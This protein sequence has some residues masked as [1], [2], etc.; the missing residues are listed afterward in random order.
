MNADTCQRWRQGRESYRPAGEPIDPR[1]YRVDLIDEAAA[2]AFVVGHHYS[3]SYPAAVCRAG[4]FRV[5][6]G[7][8]V[9]LVGA[10]VFG[11]PIQP[12][13]LRVHCGVEPSAGTELSRFVLLDDVEANGE[14]WFLARAFRLLRTEKPHISA[15]LAYS[16]PM[17]RTTAAGVVVKPGHVGTIYRAFNGERTGS[18][19]PRTLV[20]AP[21]GRVVSGRML[22]KLRT[23]DRGAAYAYRALLELG[24]PARQLGE[25]DEAYVARALRDGPWRR[26]RHPG[27]LAYSWTLQATRRSANQLTLALEGTA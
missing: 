5:A 2:K 13:S 4:L 24:A 26:V 27:N 1:R 21:D 15:V 12:A 8:G 9:E 20:L 7:G 14:T 11:V 17:E 10:A 3:R 19:S 25:G 22:T 16:D 6:S 18:S 23:G